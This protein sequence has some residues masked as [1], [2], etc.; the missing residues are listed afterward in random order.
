MRQRMVWPAAG[1]AAFCAVC[2]ASAY[3]Q[4]PADEHAAHMM[5]AQGGGSVPGDVNQ[6]PNLPPDNAGAK[7][8]LAA[9]P[10][11]GEW[12]DIPV[13]DGPALKS[14]VVYPERKDNGPVVIVVH[15]I[16]GMSDWARAIGDQLAKEGFIAIV[17]DLL[18]GKGPNGGGTESLGDQVGQTISHLTREELRVRLDAVMDYGKK[19][20]SS[21][22]KTGTVGFCWGGGTVFA[23]ALAQPYLDATVSY[24]GPM[25]SEP[26]EFGG[27]R[28]TPVLG[29][30]GG[31]DN[32][33]NANIPVSETAFKRANSIYEPHVFDGAG[34]GF[35][36][37][38]TGADG[39]NFKAAEQA[40]PLTI[41]F[42]RKFTDK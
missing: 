21:N 35:L 30:Y 38:Q 22:H 13:H 9:S 1:V 24:Y 6:N 4:T 41:A 8:R 3:G 5:A 15:D 28:P 26:T 37:N 16:G 19:L 20:P 2:A 27:G 40:W 17:P 11:H 42:L 29:L 32:R 10:R 34:H 25:P 23:Y 39:A 12:V 31:N 33:V 18:S 14:F 36:R 7:D